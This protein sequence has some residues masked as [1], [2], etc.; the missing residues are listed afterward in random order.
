VNSCH[1]EPVAQLTGCWEQEAWCSA[2]LGAPPCSATDGP[3]PATTWAASACASEN[4]AVFPGASGLLNVTVPAVPAALTLVKEVPGP[5]YPVGPYGQP[6]AERKT[7]HA[8]RPA[9]VNTP[10]LAV[11]VSELTVPLD[12][13]TTPTRVDAEPS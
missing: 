13:F 1:R 7:L 12:E 8:P 10:V 4:H 11:I 2:G 3:P 6:R 5:S 9:K